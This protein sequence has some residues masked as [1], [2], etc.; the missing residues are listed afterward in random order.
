MYMC[1]KIADTIDDKDAIN[2][3]SYE[4]SAAAYKKIG[5][6]AHEICYFWLYMYQFIMSQL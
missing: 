3:G 1:K 4:I 5:G 6:H 2:K